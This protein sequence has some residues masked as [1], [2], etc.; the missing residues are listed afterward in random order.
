MVYAPDDALGNQIGQDSV[1]RGV[2]LAEDERQLR[3]IDERR[4]AEG[5]K[6]L[7]IG[8]CHTS[9]VAIYWH[10]GRPSHD[11]ASAWESAKSAFTQRTR[12]LD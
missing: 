1:D 6:Q 7:S 10:G 2:R 9:S 4:P 8:E 11:S 12:G 3:R 5:G